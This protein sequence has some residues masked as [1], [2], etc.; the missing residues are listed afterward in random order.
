MK[1]TISSLVLE[2][3][4]T[5]NKSFRQVF[6]AGKAR[7][8]AAQ[9]ALWDKVRGGDGGERSRAKEAQEIQRRH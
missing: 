5:I 6:R 7:I 9:K 4:R 1:T 8:E 3:N 2:N